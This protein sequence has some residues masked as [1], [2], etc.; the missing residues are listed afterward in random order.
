[1][2]YLEQKV[3]ELIGE[4]V[5]SPD[6]FT[7]DDEGISQV[8]DSINDA[9]QE[10]AI[11]TGGY[12]RQYLLPLRSGQA[13]YRFRPRNGYFGWVTDCWDITRK[14]R[15]EQ[16]DPIKLSRFDPRWMTSSGSCE[17]YMQL[18]EDVIGF[19]RKPTSSA[20]GMEITIVEIPH[21]YTTDRDRIK[22]RDSFQSAVVHFAVGEFWASRG[23]AKEATNHGR[24]YMD[25]LG[26]KEDYAMSRWATP[27][28][29][30]A[31]D[32]W[33]KATS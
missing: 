25:T 8:R 20:G 24:I 28:F 15:L 32:P 18:G 5:E 13:F 12:K 4:S 14:V 17:A 33:P 3:L 6:V 31:K 11:I 7:D 27:T 9:I 21:A 19:Y 16:T 1:M 10:I 2:N 23:D 26:L 29:T 30:V 22:L